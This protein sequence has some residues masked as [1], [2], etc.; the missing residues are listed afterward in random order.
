[1]T[2]GNGAP[3]VSGSPAN[4]GGGLPN[5][6]P[7]P[8]GQGQGGSSEGAFGGPGGPGQG[9]L[10]VPVTPARV[11]GRPTS[12]AGVAGQQVRSGSRWSLSNW[13]V[14]WRLIAI[15]AV[16]TLTALIL[17]AIQISTAV[18][19]YTSFKR[20][21]TLANLNALVVTAAGQLA[22]E[23]DVTAG[24]VAS[25]KTNNAMQAQVNQDRPMR[26]HARARV[27]AAASACRFRARRTLAC[28]TCRRWRVRS[29]D[30]S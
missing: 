22:D 7:L 11:G 27:C 24:F 18:G 15:I 23:R 8:V 29:S 21:Q 19:N 25:G 16:P 1:M 14:R 30:R 5:G 10:P 20:V 3:P 12:P 26:Q 4:G 17:G 13:R 28:G 6:G 9:G 2:N